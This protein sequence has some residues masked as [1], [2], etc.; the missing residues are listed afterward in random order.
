MNVKD[1]VG[2]LE[3]CI[4]DN[5]NLYHWLYSIYDKVNN[6]ERWHNDYY[7]EV[8]FK[9]VK[10]DGISTNIFINIENNKRI[11]IKIE[12]DRIFNS[13]SKEMVLYYDEVLAFNINDLAFYNYVSAFRKI[14]Y[15][16]RNYKF[17]KFSGKFIDLENICPCVKYQK[18]IKKALTRFTKNNTN[19]ITNSDICAVCYDTTT[20]KTSCNHAICLVC[21]DR[22]AQNINMN[23]PDRSPAEHP[24]ICPICRNDIN[25]N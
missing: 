11:E 22:I 18:S 25:D 8:L 4:T 5:F 16:L 17:D 6:D 20:N 21:L 14:D 2:E 7:G 15:I 24:I 9:S 23:D 19:I 3:D 10:M 13:I 1:I 12:S